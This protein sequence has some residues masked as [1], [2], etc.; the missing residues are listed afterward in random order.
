MS[1]D[2]EPCTLCVFSNS[3]NNMTPNPPSPSHYLIICVV[4]ILLPTDEKC[5]RESQ[6]FLTVFLVWSNVWSSDRWHYF[7]FLALIIFTRRELWTFLPVL[8][9]WSNSWYLRSLSLPASSSSTL[10]RHHQTHPLR[11]LRLGWVKYWVTPHCLPLLSLLSF[12]FYG[13]L[14]WCCYIELAIFVI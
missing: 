5:R 7:S 14:Y 2:F 6:T 11:P 12:Y 8:L 9:V 3:K 1:L 4:L 10:P 13:D